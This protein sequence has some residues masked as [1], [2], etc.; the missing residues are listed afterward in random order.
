MA[1]DFAAGAGS[2]WRVN[3]DFSCVR[4]RQGL[5]ISNGLAWSQ[6][7]GTLY[8]IDSPT[9]QCDGLPAHQLR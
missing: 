3:P 7:R 9:L 8:F 1:Y 2:L 5:T 6:D 4:Q